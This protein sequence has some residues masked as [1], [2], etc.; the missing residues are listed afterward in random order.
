M[1][2]VGKISMQREEF[3]K[4]IRVRARELGLSI[5]KLARQTGISRQS[6]YD[7]F[8]GA[9]EQAKLSTVISLANTLQVHPIHLFRYLLDQ[10]ETPRYGIKEGDAFEFIRDVTIPTNT[11]VKINQTFVKT[12]EIKNI[13]KTAWIGRKLVCLDQPVDANYA[14]PK[15]KMLTTC[16]GLIAVSSEIN[17]KDTKVGKTVLISVEFKAPNYPCL[18]MSYWKLTDEDGN[19]ASSLNEGL[20][21]YVNVV[22]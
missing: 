8:S 21:C 16:R 22:E 4:Y 1:K 2:Y 20:S 9:T 15:S 19:L 7:L 13:G 18:V 3:A 14:P 5:T 6:L 12:W 17:I 11:Q 10:V